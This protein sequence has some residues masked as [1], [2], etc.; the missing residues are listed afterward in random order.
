MRSFGRAVHVLSDW[1]VTTPAGSSF[2]LCG[3]ARFRR[4]HP[5][6]AWHAVWLPVQG[7]SARSPGVWGHS[8]AGPGGGRVWPDGPPPGAMRMLALCTNAV[9]TTLRLRDRACLWG[10]GPIRR[11]DGLA[12]GAEGLAGSRRASPRC[13][14][15]GANASV[16][17]YVPFVDAAARR[18]EPRRRLASFFFDV[19]AA[20]MLGSPHGRGRG[21]GGRSVTGVRFKPWSQS[22]DR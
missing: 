22:D 7:S 14:L 6:R 2:L 1:R 10:P 11:D 16:A 17:V 15:T 13:E 3:I 21:F 4:S 19:C 20:K 18:G 12:Y 5:R 8:S 9:R